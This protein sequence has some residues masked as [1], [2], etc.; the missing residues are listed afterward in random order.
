MGQPLGGTHS[1]LRTAGPRKDGA[2]GGGQTENP[3]EAIGCTACA[4][5]HAADVETLRA[6]SMSGKGNPPRH[7]PQTPAAKRAP[8]PSA[9][10]SRA[11][12]VQCQPRGQRQPRA[13][14]A[15]GL[16]RGDRCPSEQREWCGRSEEVSPA[17]CLSQAGLGGEIRG[18]QRIHVRLL[19]GLVT[20]PGGQPRASPFWT[21]AP[22]TFAGH[23]SGRGAGSSAHSGHSPDSGGREGLSVRNHGHLQSRK[24]TRRNLGLTERR[25]LCQ[26]RRPRAAPGGDPTGCSSKAELAR[27]PLLSLVSK[28]KA[29]LLQ[30]TQRPF[31]RPRRLDAAGPARHE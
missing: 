29:A 26:A 20:P 30:K 15:S 21:C 22:R 4:R 13:A 28:R 10:D 12:K 23:S 7:R 18:D 9:G 6:I 14:R 31:G 19:G 27:T 5:D 25:P 3:V 2:G 11:L 24:P 16:A 1:R 17:L 8:R